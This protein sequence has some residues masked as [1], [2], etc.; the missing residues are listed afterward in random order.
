MREKLPYSV[1]RRRRQL[2]AERR[3]AQVG[4][5]VDRHLIQRVVLIG[6]TEIRR[7]NLIPPDAFPYNNE[8]IYQDFEVLEYD[9]GNYEPVL[10]MALEAIGYGTFK[11]P[12]R[13]PV[14]SSPRR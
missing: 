7:R 11:E 12:R 5:D 6:A 10:D 14:G 8:I 2:A 9:S 4:N 3:V 1:C 13:W